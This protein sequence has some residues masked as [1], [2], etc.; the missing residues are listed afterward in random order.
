[1]GKRKWKRIVVGMLVWGNKGEI[2]VQL[3]TNLCPDQLGQTADELRGGVDAE[4]DG[5]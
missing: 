4:V 5:F 2:R 1:M 3:H